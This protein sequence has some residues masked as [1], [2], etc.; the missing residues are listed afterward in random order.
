MLLRP[1]RPYDSRGDLP[2]LQP[3]E[4][5]VGRG[6]VSNQIPG[7]VD[8]TGPGTTLGGARVLVLEPEHVNPKGIWKR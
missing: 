4:V 3:G 6:R 7:D 2:K 5:G 8:T 1:E